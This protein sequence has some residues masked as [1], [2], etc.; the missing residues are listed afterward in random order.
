M[1]FFKRSACSLTKLIAYFLF[2]PSLQI[3]R[4]ETQPYTMCYPLPFAVLEFIIGGPDRQNLTALTDLEIV[5]QL[6]QMIDV[7]KLLDYRHSNWRKSGVARLKCFSSRVI[8]GT[9]PPGEWKVREQEL[10]KFFEPYEQ[11][12]LSVTLY[13]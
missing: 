8:I 1:R 11:D 4:I 12:G 13:T 2:A 3:L 5:V 7:K 9:Q 6:P 10:W